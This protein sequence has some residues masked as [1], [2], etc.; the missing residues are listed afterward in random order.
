MTLFT[1]IPKYKLLGNYKKWKIEKWFEAEMFKKL[2]KDQYICYHVADIWYSYKFLDCHI[3]SPI[4][5]LG[6]IEF[7]KINIDTFNVS[8]F[9]ESQIVLMKELDRRNPN[10]CR[11]MIFSVKN[12]DY[13]TLRF[14]EIRNNKNEKWWIKLWNKGKKIWIEKHLG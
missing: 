4:W 8:Q 11:V 14:S 2:R 3:V 7:K 10:I 5:E 6:W 12:N 9:E 13:V 1:D